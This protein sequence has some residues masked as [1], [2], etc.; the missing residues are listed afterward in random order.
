MT[1]AVPGNTVKIK[2]TTDSS[3][4]RYG[5]RLT[6]IVAKNVPGVPGTNEDDANPWRYRGEYL[7]LETHTYYL[8]ARSYQPTIGRFLTEDPAHDGMN[9]YVYAANNPV[10]FID[11]WGM[12]IV[13]L[14]EWFD[15][16]YNSAQQT[17]GASNISGSLGWND[18]SRTA[19]VF[20]AGN[21]AS[22]SAN[23]TAGVNGSYI[24]ASSGRMYV[25]DIYLWAALGKVIDPPLKVDAVSYAAALAV[26]AVGVKAVP[27]AA[28]VIKQAAAK[29]TI[30]AITSGTLSLDKIPTG[31]SNA[32]NLG[33]QAAQNAMQT[34]GDYTVKSYHLMSG[35]GGYSKF[36]TDS[37]STANQ[38]VT[39][40]LSMA[41]SFVVNSGDSIYTV[42]GMGRTVGTKGEQYIK[43]V[44]SVAGKIISAYL[45]KVSG[46][47]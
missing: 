47:N 32:L 6:S 22:G 2:L 12:A 24:D 33:Q 25:D 31:I 28:A 20:M 29:A 34:V 16:Q 4:T 35:S 7:D 42:V 14:R 17:Y 5:F 10:M 3:I 9:W 39:N 27:A 30:G 1:I 15:Y 11:P 43:I 21:G 26:S 41:N 13:Q 8:R 36:A 38:W 19:S 46:G 23:F 44:F 40:A 18:A 45:N 37:L